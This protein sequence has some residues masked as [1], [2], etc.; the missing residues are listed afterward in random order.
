MSFNP[1]Q[2][3]PACGV[4][5]VDSTSGNA[6]VGIVSWLRELRLLMT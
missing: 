6:K 2:V 4:C 1:D 3:L 5:R